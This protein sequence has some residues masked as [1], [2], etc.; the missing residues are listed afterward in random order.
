MKQKSTKTS[1]RDKHDHDTERVLRA[2]GSRRKNKK[3]LAAIDD[4]QQRRNAFSLKLLD[5]EL[6]DTKQNIELFAKSLKGR[7]DVLVKSMKAFELIETGNHGIAHRAVQLESEVDRL[8]LLLKLQAELSKTEK[9]A[10]VT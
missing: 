10:S 8:R 9:G 2:L 5:D 6:R 4:V 1:N 7:C 3:A